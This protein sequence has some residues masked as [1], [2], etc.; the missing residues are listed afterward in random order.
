MPTYYLDVAVGN[1]GNLGTSAGAGNAWASFAKARATVA[2]GDKVWVK[3]SGNYI[4][5]D[6][7]TGAVCDIST[8]G[9]AGAW[10]EWEGYDDSPSDGVY[11]SVTVDADANTL[12]SAILSSIGGNA[13]NAFVNFRF[14]GAS[15]MGA[16][17]A[18]EKFLNFTR[19][20]FDNNDSHG[21]HTDS[22]CKVVACSCDSNGGVGWESD[23]RS[24]TMYSIFHTNTGSGVTPGSNNFHEGCIF[25]AN[26]SPLATGSGN[27]NIYTNCVFD[28]ENTLA[29]LTITGQCCAVTNSIF[30]DC[31]TG[32]T[33]VAGGEPGNT[34]LGNLYYSNTA[35][36]SNWPTD[37]TDV[38]G[39]PAFTNEA[40]DDYT[41]GAGSPAIGA[42]YSVS[43]LLGETENMDIGAHQKTISSSGLLVHPG[44]SGGARG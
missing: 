12:V 13:Y 19:C 10:I 24:S 25:Y 41:L 28:G 40:G 34:S 9:T 23:S 7:A 17:F 26:G 8:A 36:V 3:S 31:T 39:D 30:Y 33:G 38:A 14:T 16:D 15:G 4:T 20:R 29:G 18:S 42:G 32:V 27:Q 2:A 22:D 43:T 1:D 37:P 35:D 44:M 21:L 6:G 5:Q 11:G